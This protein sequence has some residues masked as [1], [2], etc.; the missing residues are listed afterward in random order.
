MWGIYQI[1][2]KTLEEMQ[3]NLDDHFVNDL[4]LLEQ[5]FGDELDTVTKNGAER[6]ALINLWNAAE[7]ELFAKY[8]L[9]KRQLQFKGYKEELDD[10][11]ESLNERMNEYTSYLRD[12]NKHVA[13]IPLAEL[14]AVDILNMNVDDL[15]PRDLSDF[16]KLVKDQLNLQGIKGWLEQEWEKNVAAASRRGLRLVKE[17]IKSQGL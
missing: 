16:Q 15:L 10:L 9:A 13:G 5:K 17:N 2:E 8:K 11:K 12:L 4:R 14:T 7:L 3:G 6:R 1:Q